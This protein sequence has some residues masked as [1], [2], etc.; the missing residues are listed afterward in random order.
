MHLPPITI[1]DRPPLHKRARYASYLLP[2]DISVY[3]ENSGSTLTTP[4]YLPDILPTD[5]QKN[6]HDM[7]KGQPV[8]GRVHRGY[9]CRIHGQIQCYKKTR[10]YCSTCSDE[11]NKFNYCQGFSSST[12]ATRTCF[13]EH[14]H[15]MSLGYGLLLCFFSLPYF[16]L[17]VELVLCLITS[18]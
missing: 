16:T 18:D 6:V 17:P 4:S 11:D 13:L 12:V 10:F 9:C 15:T 2:D 8:N 1:D 7:K 14:Q 5:G 3:S